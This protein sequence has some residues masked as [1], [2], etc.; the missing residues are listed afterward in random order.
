VD[1][2]EFFSES[3]AKATSSAR[4]MSNSHQQFISIEK[5]KL[6]QCVGEKQVVVVAAF[7]LL[8]GVLRFVCKGSSFSFHNSLFMRQK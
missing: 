6:Q 8:V 4:A 3:S 1:I 2:A 5:S 7:G